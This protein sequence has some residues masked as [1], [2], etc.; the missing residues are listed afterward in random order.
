MGVLCLMA[1]NFGGDAGGK[2]CT[3]GSC[4]ASSDARI[5]Q[6]ERI[7]FRFCVHQSKSTVHSSSFYVMFVSKIVQ[8]KGTNKTWKT[9]AFELFF[10]PLQL[11]MLKLQKLDQTIQHN[12]A[13]YKDKC[14]LW[15]IKLGLTSFSHH[16][17]DYNTH[18]SINYF[19]MF[20][21]QFW[22]I[23]IGIAQ[24]IG[25]SWIY[26]KFQK[27]SYKRDIR[28]RHSYVLLAI[29]LAEEEKLRCSIIE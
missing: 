1:L 8:D 21:T 6:C 12:Y 5:R 23:V 17:N 18:T 26:S 19:I 28:S 14:Y 10:S 13:K 29:L 11:E 27:R 16:I 9:T 15:H 20:S 22:L 24:R 4:T 25:C 2:S 7:F 3:W